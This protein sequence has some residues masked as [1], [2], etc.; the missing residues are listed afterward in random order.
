MARSVNIEVLRAYGVVLRDSRR[1][2]GLSQEKLSSEATESGLTPG[3]TH[4]SALERGRKEPGLGVQF[5][6]A[7]KIGVRLSEMFRSVEEIA[8]PAAERQRI[9]RNS[10]ARIPLG[11]E[12]CPR[13]KT[14]Y[15]VYAVRLKSSERGKFRCCKKPIASWSGTTRLVYETIRLPKGR[16]A[17]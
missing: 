1:A 9:D 17:K 13:C 5:R 2:A 12:I 8:L 11:T 15:S 3:R 7:R 14:V 6:L 10:D 4:V 16:R